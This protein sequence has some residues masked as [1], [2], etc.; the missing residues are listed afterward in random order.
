MVYAIKATEENLHQLT[1]M[2]T[3]PE[4]Q[5]ENSHNNAHKSESS[6]KVFVAFLQSSGD[7]VMVADFSVWSAIIF[8][9]FGHL[10]YHNVKGAKVIRLFKCSN[11][12]PKPA[13]KS[14]NK[15]NT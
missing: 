7:L 2:K 13:P 9:P 1:S 10:P 12:W 3:L 4:S 5:V 8:Y 6:R 14:R 15:Y 11:R